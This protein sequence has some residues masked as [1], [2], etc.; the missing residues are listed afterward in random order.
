M[1][2]DTLIRETA[3]KSEA[4]DRDFEKDDGGTIYQALVA[5]NHDA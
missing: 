5:Q 2:A 3:S 1:T 4:C